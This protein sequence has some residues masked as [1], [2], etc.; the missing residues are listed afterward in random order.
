MFSTEMSNVTE[1]Y[2]K[3]QKNRENVGVE[4][5]FCSVTT[6]VMFLAKRED[7]TNTNVKSKSYRNMSKRGSDAKRRHILKTY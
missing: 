3:C 2:Q 6:S 5:P 1:I 7:V 4:A